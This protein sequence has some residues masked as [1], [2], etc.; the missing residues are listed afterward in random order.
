MHRI[1]R[2][3]KR[4]PECLRQQP[5]TKLIKRGVYAKKLTKK[6]IIAVLEVYYGKKETGKNNKPILAEILKSENLWDEYV[7]HTN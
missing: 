1:R 3:V 5:K 7:L 4:K 2:H 6:E